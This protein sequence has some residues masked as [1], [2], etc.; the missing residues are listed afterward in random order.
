MGARKNSKYNSIYTEIRTAIVN[1]RFAPG[2]QL[3]TEY[4]LCQKYSVS[5][6]TVTRA[7]NKLQ[8][9]GLVHRRSGAGSFVSSALDSSSK[10]SQLYFGLLIP[11]LG[12]TEI[13]EPICA[14]IAQ[15]SRSNNFHI[16]WGD[17]GAHGDSPLVEA[18][19]DTCRRYIEA[20][21]SGVFFVPLELVDGHREGNRRIA[22]M[23]NE[24][25]IPIVLLDADYLPFPERS[26]S[27]LV[28]VDNVQAGYTLTNHLIEHGA[29]RVDYLYR[30]NSAQTIFAR[31]RGYKCALLDAGIVPSNSWI[32][33]AEPGDADE[34]RSLLEGGASD[35]VCANDATAVMLA[36]TLEE[37]KVRVPK[38]VRVTGMD[39]VKYSKYSRVPLTTVRQPCDTIGRLAV[40]AMMSRLKNRGA[41][42]VTFSAQPELMVRRSSIRESS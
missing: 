30:P 10:P 37:L 20:K 32:H 26:N 14:S 3:P 41:E 25:D 2:D 8:S 5:R 38:D 11:R 40:T 42:A 16:L 39:D 36:H 18:A 28:G 1:E 22:Q 33:E 35:I 17:S 23:L 19:E 13:F 4:E 9:E 29:T 7:L 6:P 34:V 24:A 15:Q 27:D 31:I 12:V 21:V